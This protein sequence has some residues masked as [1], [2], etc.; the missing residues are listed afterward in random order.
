MLA[1]YLS[2]REISSGELRELLEQHVIRE[3]VPNFFV[4]LKK[5]PLTLNGKVNL[6]ALPSLQEIREKTSSA[7]GYVAP[8]S[9]TEELLAGIWSQLLGIGKVGIHA[10]FF[11]LG[12]HSLLATQMVSR[13]GRVFSVELPLRAVFEALTVAALAGRIDDE[14]SHRGGISM[15]SISRISRLQPMPLSFAQ[16]RL[17]F[18]DQLQ[19]GNIAYNVP[20]AVELKGELDVPALCAALEEVVRRHEIL[21]TRFVEREGVPFQEVVEDFQLVVEQIDLSEWPAAEREEE[22]RRQAHAQAAKPF[23]LDEGGLLRVKILRVAENDHVLLVVMHHI[24]TD[25]WSMNIVTQETVLAYEARCANQPS[26]LQPMEIQYAD[27][28]AWERSWLQGEVLQKHLDYWKKQLHG[29]HAMELQVD[30][31][32]RKGRSPGSW[33]RFEVPQD[34]SAELSRFCREQ[35]VTL[36]MGLLTAF[37]IL[38]GKYTALTDISVGGLVANRAHSQSEALIGFFANT[39]V[40]RTDLG[41]DPSFLAALRQVRDM[42]FEAHEHQSLPFETLVKELQLDRE[43]ADKAVAPVL[44]SFQN[45]QSGGPTFSKLKAV[46]VN[47]DSGHV[48]KYDL[49]LQMRD[50]GQSIVGV[51]DYNAELFESGTIQQ[52]NSHFLNLLRNVLRDPSAPIS[53]ITLLADGETERLLTRPELTDLVTGDLSF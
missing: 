16:Q 1:F 24:V 25:E 53:R 11:E 34:V 13:I 33:L 12:G 17:W 21:R 27:Y 29:M 42:T 28:A 22:V 7:A 26:P 46:E 31:P 15:Q 36:Y 3:T 40:L 19:P 52:M 41:R 50:A 32:R 23:K 48:A 20:L 10:N 14:R 9:A 8:R 30:H 38:L 49:Y 2:R 35:N 37:N 4:H 44:F 47:A 6:A 5:L 43:L 18:M 51:W 45:S 39:L